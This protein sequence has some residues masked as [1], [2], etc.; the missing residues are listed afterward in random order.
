MMVP[1]KPLFDSEEVLCLDIRETVLSQLS[2]GSMGCF[3]VCHRRSGVAVVMKHGNVV[4][5][6]YE[7]TKCITKV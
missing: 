5:V 6:G 3:K 4:V 1:V 2:Q 7:R